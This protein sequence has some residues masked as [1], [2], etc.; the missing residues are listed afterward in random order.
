MNETRTETASYVDDGADRLNAEVGSGISGSSRWA[1]L[2]GDPSIVTVGLSLCSGVAG[3]SLML[4]HVPDETDP[5]VSNPV[6]VDD[7]LADDL[8]ARRSVE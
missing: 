2:H 7:P 1:T 8:A 5:V 3:A 4:I 6:E